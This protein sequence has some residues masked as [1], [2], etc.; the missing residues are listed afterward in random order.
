MPRDDERG[1]F[2]TATDILQTVGGSPAVRLRV[3]DIGSAMKA[4][5]YQQYRSHGRRGYR[6]VPY[7]T[8]EIESNRTQLAYDARPESEALA[9]D[10]AAGVTGDTGVTVF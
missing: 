10:P 5:G 3:E 7:K 2:Y 4:L 9:S 6:V 8:E 1:Q